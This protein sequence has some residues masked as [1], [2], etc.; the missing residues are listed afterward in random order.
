MN[1]LRA[2]LFLIAG[3]VAGYYSCEFFAKQQLPTII[4]PTNIEPSIQLKK[5]SIEKEQVYLSKLDSL[6]KSNAVLARQASNSK[7]ELQKAKDEHQVLLQLVDTIIANEN[8]TKDTAAKLAACDSLESTILCMM[9]VSA[10]KDSL[11]DS[12]VI[13]LENEVCNR[14]SCIN[15][16]KEAYNSIQISFDKCLSQQELLSI[17][18]LQLDK[19]FHK[20]VIGNKLLKT[21]LIIL[22]GITTYSLL[23]HLH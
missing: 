20:Q 7:S 18:N 19:Q 13:S 17:Q 14:D 9:L 12:L 11:Y 5:S 23:N 4:T 3:L 1:N 6:E 2:F 22:S 10:Q 21:G 8:S 15:V 16:Q